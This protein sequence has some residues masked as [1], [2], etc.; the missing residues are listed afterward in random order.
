METSALPEEEREPEG[1]REGA[2]GIRVNTPLRP[3]SV[4][5][6]PRA[7]GGC[8]PCHCTE[9]LLPPKEPT[10][11]VPSSLHFRKITAS[12][13]KMYC[14]SC[15]LGYAFC[16]ALQ[17]VFAHI[18]S[19]PTALGNPLRIVIWNTK[20]NN[21]KSTQLVVSLLSRDWGRIVTEM[22]LSFPE[23]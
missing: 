23:K 8:P 9:E 21:R 3:S 6:V 14:C 13:T 5:P 2:R 17:L 18:G 12:S 19:S 10:T 20:T 1:G 22:K 4:L 7:S 11:H 15:N 16:L